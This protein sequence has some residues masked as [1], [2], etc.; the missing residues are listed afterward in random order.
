MPIEHIVG[1]GVDGPFI[2]FEAN[3]QVGQISA[4]QSVELVRQIEARALIAVLH[5]RDEGVDAPRMLVAKTRAQRPAGCIEQR[6]PRDD[7]GRR[8]GFG[9]RGIGEAHALR[10]GEPPRQFCLQFCLAALH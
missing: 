10:E 7:G 5:L 2:G 4:R 8:V 9:K 3:A 6:L 1:E